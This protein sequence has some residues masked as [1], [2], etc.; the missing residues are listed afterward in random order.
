MF[1]GGLR[2][3]E[4]KEISI[5][6]VSFTAMKKLLDYIYTSEIELDLECVQDVLVAAT[7]LQVSTSCLLFPV[8]CPAAASQPG[9]SLQLDVVI[10]FCCDFLF[11]WLDETNV[12]EVYRLADVYGLQQLQAKVHS[13]L[14]RNIQTFS[15]TEGYRL[16]PPDEVFRALS[17]DQL[18]VSSENQAYEAALHY[19]FSPEQVE[20]NQVCLQVS[21]KVRRFAR[22][23]RRQAA[24]LLVNVSGAS[25]SGAPADAGRRPL[26]PD[27]A[28]GAAEAAPAPGPVSA[29]G[30]RLR[31]AALPPAGAAAARPA[32]SSHAAALHA[33]VH[34][35]IRRQVRLQLL[36]QQPEL[37]PDLPPQL[38][39]VEDAARVSEPPDVQPGHRRPQQ[40][41]L[42]D[43]RRPEHRRVSGGGA[44]LEV[45]ALPDEKH[46][47]LDEARS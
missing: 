45:A 12:V 2:E 47:I 41:R 34:P 33:A 27:G 13:Y 8:S 39:G 30:R 19:H 31:R 9:V 4:Q 29:E 43:R 46:L 28:A 20:S 5:H 18:Q 24:L 40:L 44:L 25:P 23:G 7:V 17:S 37:V 38:G 15:R 32:E 36:H 1:A 6:G 11:S 21:V 26:L 16:L 22:T 3:A 10:G 35:G 42:R 14:L